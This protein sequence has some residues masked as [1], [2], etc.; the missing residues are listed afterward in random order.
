MSD[1]DDVLERLLNE[2]AFAAALA[3]D[4]D[5]AL[6][7]YRLDA[8]EAALLRSQVVG[9][10][11]ADVAKVETRTSKSS[12]FGLLAPFA[13]LGGVVDEFG[14][15]LADPGGGGAAGAREAF[16]AA[17]VAHQGIGNAPGFGDAPVRQGLG[18][19]P[20]RQGLGD[21]PQQG[22]G[23]APHQSL[24]EPGRGH[25]EA[26]QLAPPPGYANRVDADGDGHWDRATYRGGRDGGADILVDLDHDGRADFIG[27]D[28]DL[29]NKVDYADYDTDS[30]GVFDK[31]MY[32]DDN[33]GWLD[34]TVRRRSDP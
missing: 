22:L 10:T 16:G 32:D 8:G 15:H 17:P 12:T 3:D 33:D 18:T 14:Q 9:D 7:G 4:P 19:A 25:A 20:V 28:V 1:F 30:D 5:L 24:G 31:R 29:D 26:E 21:A 2:P 6:A 11:A 23:G 34:R 27:H 13:A